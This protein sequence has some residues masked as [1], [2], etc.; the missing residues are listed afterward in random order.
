MLTIS[1]GSAQ[2]LAGCNDC[3][4]GKYS[5]EGKTACVDCGVGTVSAP[6]S[7]AAEDCSVCPTNKINEV[8]GNATCADCAGGSFTVGDSAGDHDNINDCKTCG[9]GEFWKLT[10]DDAGCQN[11]EAG[12]K[13]STT[14]NFGCD[15]CEANSIS[16]AGPASCTPCNDGTEARNA[17]GEPVTSSATQCVP[18]EAGKSE[19]GNSCVECSGNTFT[20]A[21]GQTSCADCGTSSQVAN[22]AKTSCAA[23]GAGKYFSSEAACVDC[24]QGYVR[25]AETAARAVCTQCAE[26]TYSNVAKTACTAC[27]D[28]KVSAAG[29]FSEGN[30]VSVAFVS[31][32]PAGTFQESEDSDVATCKCRPGFGD[33]SADPQCPECALGSYRGGYSRAA[34][35][36]CE[37]FLAGSIT[38]ATQR[39]SSSDCV[40]R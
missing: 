3:A 12:K 40:C 31:P 30:C 16:G 24:S 25:P 13:G 39:T 4:G 19:S 38:L 21:A 26:N 9:G 22:E 36:S 8:A 10:G 34:C 2:G 20:S 18:C 7:D 32:C 5:N 1:L 17:A 6:R 37:T 28:G 35:S 33:Y 15:A 29:S 23:C 27:G 14:D 11:C